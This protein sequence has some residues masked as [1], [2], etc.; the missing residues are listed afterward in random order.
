MAVTA[1]RSISHAAPVGKWSTMT[2]EAWSGVTSGRSGTAACR[3]L[4]AVRR[5]RTA[6]SAFIAQ[7][8]PTHRRALVRHPRYRAQHQPRLVFGT[9]RAHPVPYPE[10]AGLPWRDELFRAQAAGHPWAFLGADVD[11]WFARGEFLYIDRRDD[12]GKDYANRPSVTATAPGNRCCPAPSIDSGST[13]TAC[14]NAMAPG[15]RYCATI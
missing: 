14:R 10:Q 12:Y 1:D 15:R 2:A 7:P 5:A 3:S 11:N 9:G 4:A 6:A 8:Q 13:P